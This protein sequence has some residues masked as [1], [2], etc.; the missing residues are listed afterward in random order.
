MTDKFQG[1][2]L[3]DSI[4]ESILNSSIMAVGQEN[5]AESAEMES[6]QD[7]YKVWKEI[8]LTVQKQ[9]QYCNQRYNDSF[10][11]MCE[12]E[13]KINA[14][15][16]KGDALTEACEKTR[17]KRAAVGK[18]IASLQESI[19]ET[20]K[21]IASLEQKVRDLE[22][23]KEIY[24]ILR[25]IPV[26]NIFSEIIAAIDGTRSQLQAKKDELHKRSGDLQNL[27]NEWN[28]LQRE[29]EDAERKI[30]ENEMERMQLEEKRR[31]C[32]EQRNTASREMID[33]KNREK[34]CLYIEKE[35]EHLIALEADAE[36]FR[37][38]L[39]DNPPPF[40]LNF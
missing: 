15:Y 24:D 39:A 34:Y 19:N 21:E 27:R 6:G 10:Q 38:L 12:L 36:E 4:F 11:Q 2:K 29:I 13:D 22:K 26:V 40:Q 28:S 9:A 37:K 30:H 16:A 8:T 25:Y 32:Q 5:G 14:C 20:N 1:L 17:A 7:I 3:A 33:W 23:Q 18:Q 31:V 35:M